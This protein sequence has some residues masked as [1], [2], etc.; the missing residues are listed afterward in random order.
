MIS[1][2]VALHSLTDFVSIEGIKKNL[3]QTKLYHSLLFR[4]VYYGIFSTI[5][6]CWMKFY[7]KTTCFAGSWMESYGC[8]HMVL[9][10][11]LPGVLITQVKQILI[12]TI[13]K[14][15]Q[16][17]IF[18]RYFIHLESYHKHDVRCFHSSFILWLYVIVYLN[19]PVLWLDNIQTDKK[20]FS[21]AISLL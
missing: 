6:T 11:K 19:N 5:N 10:N 1:T 9:V 4:F 8:N 14:V 20:N 3:H 13:R 16:P 18:D 15:T 2:P 12:F 7:D 17:P 21:V